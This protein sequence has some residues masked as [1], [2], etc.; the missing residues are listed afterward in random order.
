MKNKKYLMAVLALVLCV[1]MLVTGC[2]NGKSGG[3][4]QNGKTDPAQTLVL[5]VGD[6]EIYLN[7]MNF[8]A[9]SFAQSYGIDENADLDAFYSTDYP[10]MDD[11]YKSQFLI[12]V[13]QSKILYIKAVEEGITLTS[14]D[15][16]LVTQSM[17]KFRNMYGEDTLSGYGI[18]DDTLKKICTEMQMVAKLQNKLSENAQYEEVDYGSFYNIVLLTIEVDEDGNAVV[19]SDGNYIPLSDEKKDEQKANAEEILARLKNGEDAEALIEEYKISDASSLLHATTESLTKTYGLKDG[20]ISDII[21]NDYGYKIVKIVSLHDEDYTA[22][23]NEYNKSNAS[24]EAVDAQM[25]A[26]FD[27]FVINEDDLDADVWAKF[28]FKDFV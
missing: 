10:T 3:N 27:E 6:E 8:Y 22:T 24:S 28:T 17:D 18:D 9:L 16:E 26:W 2:G 20:E 1:S 4:G 5:K 15:E 11:A 19:D 12:G 25:N 7:E 21:D 13:R 23:V 14:E